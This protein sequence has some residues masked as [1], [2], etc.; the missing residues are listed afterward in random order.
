[1]RGEFAAAVAEEGLRTEPFERGLDLLEAMLS[2]EGTVN[3]APRRFTFTV[4][5]PERAT[6]NDFVPR[7]WATRRVGALLDRI[8]LDGESAE[9]REEATELARRYG[10]VTPWTSYLVLEDEARRNVPISA[11]GIRSASLIASSRFFAKT[12]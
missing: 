10:I 7:L 3:G 5:F 2:L 11:L 12:R 4:A 9:L 8:R 6:A 1:M